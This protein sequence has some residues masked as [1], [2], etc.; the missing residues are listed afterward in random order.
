MVLGFGTGNY[1]WTAPEAVATAIVHS[2]LTFSSLGTQAAPYVLVVVVVAVAARFEG[3]FQIFIVGV[4]IR[5][6]ILLYFIVAIL[7]FSFNLFCDKIRILRPLF[8]C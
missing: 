4:S 8:W 1:K 3:F 2:R 5:R 7:T 6:Y